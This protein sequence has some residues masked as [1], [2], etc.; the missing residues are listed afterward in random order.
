VSRSTSDPRRSRSSR[1][2]DDNMGSFPVDEAAER[3]LVA[4]ILLDP[5]IAKEECLDLIEGDM[6]THPGYRQMV[7]TVRHLVASGEGVDLISIQPHLHGSIRPEELPTLMFETVPSGANI[8]T[9]FFRVVEMYRRRRYWHLGLELT[10]SARGLG[11]SGNS[12]GLRI[13]CEQVIEEAE[14]MGSLPRIHAVK[15]VL[16]KALAAVKPEAEREPGEV[17]ETGLARLDQ[18]LVGGLRKGHMYIIAARPSMGKTTLA[19][20]I[21]SNMATDEFPVLFISLETL[22]ETL[23]QG[24]LS[25]SSGVNSYHLMRGR[26]DDLAARRIAHAADALSSLPLYV[27]DDSRITMGGLRTMVRAAKSKFGVRAVFIDYLQLITPE[28]NGQESRQVQVSMISRDAKLLAMEQ[29]LPIIMMA[30]LNRGVEGRDSKR[31]RLSDLRESGSI[32]QDADVVALMYQKG[33]YDSDNDDGNTEL[34]VAKQRHGP[35]GTVPLRF[36]AAVGD[37]SEWV[38]E[39]DQ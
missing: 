28:G 24:L 25:R 27:C 3:A 18:M 7:A 2:D 31:P 5:G 26:Y 16:P 35:C 21:A 9:H 11:E 33:Y 22:E 38:E 34:I 36:D 37:F 1:D 8:M 14:Q 32:E 6:F 29:E 15:D 30:Q 17:L 39:L 12:E 10:S 20:N 13:R 19:W 23:V 4:S